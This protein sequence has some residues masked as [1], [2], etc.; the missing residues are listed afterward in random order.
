MS[1]SSVS[2]TKAKKKTRIG[3]RM[4]SGE[5]GTPFICSFR[6]GSISEHSGLKINDVI[7]SINDVSCEGK[8]A[9]EIVDMIRGLKGTI[10]FITMEDAD[11]AIKQETRD[12]ADEITIH[13]DEDAMSPSFELALES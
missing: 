12:L 2:I 10:T 9:K 1:T 11:E 3:L 6:P 13:I 5:D 7:M 4:T 8:T